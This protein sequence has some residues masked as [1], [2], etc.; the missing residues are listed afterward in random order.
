METSSRMTAQSAGVAQSMLRRIAIDCPISK[1]H[2]WAGAVCLW[3]ALN[4][5]SERTGLLRP[6]ARAA[7]R[8]VCQ[9]GCWPPHSGQ[10]RAEPQGIGGPSSSICPRLCGRG[11]E[12]VFQASTPHAL[13]ATKRKSNA[14]AES[15][16]EP[17]N[18]P[19]RRS[20]MRPRTATSAPVTALALSEARNNIT[21]ASSAGSTQREKSAFGMSARF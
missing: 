15:K 20:H 2:P 16:R 10:R 14:C 5:F 12:S 8:T 3:A 21:S 4:G 18:A 1:P 6:S 7:G 13:H 17:R 19:G 9:A 11:R